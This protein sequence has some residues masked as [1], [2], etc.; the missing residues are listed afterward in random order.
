MADYDEKPDKPGKLPNM[1]KKENTD[2]LEKIRG[3]YKAMVDADHENRAAAM[4]DLKFINEPGAQWD[5]NMKQARGD[6]PCYQYNKLRVT[7]KRIINDMRANRPSSKVRAVEGGDKD[8][9]ELYEGLIRNIH[10]R[11]EFETITD[12]AAEYQVGGGMACWRIDTEY[13][14]DDAFNQDIWIR[15][16]E[17]PFCLYADPSAKDFMKRDAD[18][19]ILTERITH[20]EYEKRFP[21]AD[22][23]DFDVSEFDDQEDWEDDDTVRI[24]EYWYKKPHSK[25]LWLMQD[26]KVV[27]SE[28]DEAQAILA[29]GGDEMIKR[30]RM[31]ET[32]KI[33]RVLA[34]GERLL[35]EPMEWAGRKFPFVMVYGE[36]IVI[37]GKRMWFGLVRFARDAQQSYNVART[38]VTETVA[39]AP[40]GKWWATV[41]QAKGLEDVWAEAHKKNFP[42]MPYN[43]DPKASG[44]PQWMPGP[45]IPTGLVQE[46]QLASEDIKAVTGIFDPSLGSQSNETSGRAIYAR[47]Q[48]GE[49][50]T[51]NYRDNMA[52][53]VQ[54]TDELLIDLIPEIYDTQRELR[55]L[56]NDGAED[57]RKVNQVVFDPAT[58]Q[59]IRVNDLATGKYDVTVTIGPNFATQRQEAAELY[60][61]LANRNPEIMAV[62]GDLIMKSMDLPYS[63]EI[64]D[65]LKAM[66]PP[67]IQQTLNEGK[68]LPPEVMQAM[69]QAD[70]AMQQVQQQAAE[71]QQMAQE[72]QT[73]KA[74]ADKAKSEV[75]EQVAIL[76]AARAEFD[77]H[78][79][80]ETAKLV[81]K[82]ADV[83][84]KD[85]DA[86][87]ALL[88]LKEQA[89]GVMQMEEDDTRNRIAAIDDVLAQFM[90]VVDQA[91]DHL[92]NRAEQLTMA[93]NRT[94]RRGTATRKDGKLVAEVEFDDG[95]K[96]EISAVRRNGR[97][98]IVPPDAGAGTGAEVM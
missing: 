57:Y 63:E 87:R 1:Q 85:A 38:A 39:Q 79:A 89:G 90:Q 16:I 60:S 12:Y 83:R 30:R 42:W 46:L 69:Q 61:E 80:Q 5:A 68:D 26:G 78:I 50:A 33:C 54:Y 17:N 9:A 41:E 40:K 74:E 45:Q 48:Q 21:G 43:A 96:R 28:T 11:S 8:T 20:R 93:T 59:E 49:I 10:N 64:G 66:L 86:R 25:E 56:G 24:A 73:D 55:V 91:V 27:D 36:Y 98:E 34:S 65:R 44:P 94:P 23:S 47:Q 82:D 14:D 88:D 37:D 18:D 75:R 35:T 6:R 58:G 29:A 95:T 7:C 22:K 32:S 2:L 81:T 3:R 76:K 15:G 97:L 67:Q 13:S 72:A 51:F 4:D 71:V 52:K 70:Q 84:I 19:W 92:D 31:V 53:A 62:A 77:A